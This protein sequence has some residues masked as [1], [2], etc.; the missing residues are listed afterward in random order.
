[1]PVPDPIPK[2]EPKPKEDTTSTTETENKK[3]EG[4]HTETETETQTKLKQVEEPPPK[5]VETGEKD[6]PASPQ[7]IPALMMPQGHVQSFPS[8]ITGIPT[9]SA[10]SFEKTHL[11]INYYTELGF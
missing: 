3:S 6:K 7:N 11:E 9:H 1:V 4:P 10:P 8:M 5:K 2:P